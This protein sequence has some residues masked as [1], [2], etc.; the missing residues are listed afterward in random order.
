MPAQGSTLALRALGRRL[1]TLRKKAD[2]S[3]GYAASILGIS[4]QTM[5]RVEEGLSARSASDLY[6]NTLCDLYNA[7]QDERR[8]ILALAHEVRVIAKRGGGWWRAHLDQGPVDFDPYT[9]VEGAANRLTIWAVIVLPA[10]VRT[11]DYTR[12]MTW[13]LHPNEPTDQN[14][15]RIQRALKQQR[16]LDDPD[17]TVEIILSEAALREE[18]GGSAVMAEQRR[19]LA[20]IA[21]RPNVTIR[22]VPFTTRHHLGP[23]VGPFSLMEFPPMSKS[24]MTHPPIVHIEGYAGDLY[25]ERFE[26]V[27]HYKAAIP[28]LRRAALTETDS[29]ALLLHEN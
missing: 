2:I 4:P 13:T 25:L 10:I 18:W 11:P 19:H 5:G 3:Q 22:V 12:A 29:R 7:P 14:E 24:R 20:E 17:L 15:E 23:L 6:M 21:Q 9:V 1:Y 16:S 27:S 26:E 8:L 28:E